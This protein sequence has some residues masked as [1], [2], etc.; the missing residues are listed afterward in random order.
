MGY[1]FGFSNA[2]VGGFNLGALI[3]GFFGGGPIGAIGS[4]FGGGGGGLGEGDQFSR[5]DA[6][7]QK[8][9]EMQTMMQ[10][11]SM[12]SNVSKV[13]HDAGMEAVRNIKQ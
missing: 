4:L 6:L 7:F 5:L 12:R 10:E 11:F 8:Q 1:G 9:V 13:T 3:T 2:S